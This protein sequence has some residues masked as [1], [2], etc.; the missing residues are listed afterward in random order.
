MFSMLYIHIHVYMENMEHG[1]CQDHCM[2]E[3]AVVQ[4]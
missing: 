2:F 1:E 4:N 3:H